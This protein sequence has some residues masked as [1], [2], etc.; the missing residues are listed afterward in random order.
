MAFLLF[1]VAVA[2]AQDLSREIRDHSG[3]HEIADLLCD[4]L[5]HILRQ[6]PGLG[7]PGETVKNGVPRL[8]AD[9]AVNGQTGKALEGP[10]AVGR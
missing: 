5:C 2:E 9:D 7:N 10:H 1:C 3:L 4:L 6:R 8:L